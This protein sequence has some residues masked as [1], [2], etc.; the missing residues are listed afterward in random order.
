MGIVI[1]MMLSV[2][3][4]WKAMEVRQGEI[5]RTSVAAVRR[6][7]VDNDS[8]DDTLKNS[9]QVSLADLDAWD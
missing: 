8:L 1:A 7:T 4:A 9:G 2:A 6:D 3:D 5:D